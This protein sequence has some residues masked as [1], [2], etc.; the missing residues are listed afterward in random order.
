MR[1]GGNY[2][3]GGQVEFSVW[4]PFAKNISVKFH[5]NR[6]KII[7]L[8][9][10]KNGYW[11]AVVDNLSPGTQ[12]FYRINDSVDRPDPA[13]HSQPDGIH[14]SSQIVDH[15][16]FKWEDEHYG[17]HALNELIIYEIHTGTFT[18]E[19]TFDAIIA[20]LPKLT[21]LGI[22]SI[23][24]MP[25]SQF[26][27]ERNWGYDGVHPFAVQNT[28]GGPCGLKRLV[29][30]CH[31]NNFAVILDVVYNH[32]GPEGNY[33]GEFGPYFTSK[34]KTPWGDAINFDDEYSND[35][36]NFFIESALH[37][38]SN[39]HINALRID[40]V[41]GI[42]DMSAKP[43]LME[44]SETIEKFS[45]EK[46][47]NHYLI[48]ESDLNDVKIIKPRVL[49]GYG[50]D[51][52]WCDDF[53]HCVHTL[54]TGEASGYYRDFGKIEQLAKSISEGFVYSGQYSHFRKRYFG[55][56]TE[57]MHAQSFIV[58]S[59]NHDQTGNRMMGE[60]LASLT[61][62]ESLKLTAGI[63]ILSPFI[64]LIFMGEEYGETAP[65]LYFISHIDENLRQTVM[66][67]RLDEFKWNLAAQPADPGDEATFN[68]S[69]IDWDKRK[70]SILLSFYKKLI[71]IRREITA[72]CCNENNGLKTWG[73]EKDKT[74]IM[75]RY[76]GE[77]SVL[78]LF[79][80]SESDAC[81]R[82]QDGRW[83]KLLDS[84]DILWSGPGAL[85]PENTEAGKDITL[86]EKSFACYKEIKDE[87]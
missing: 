36:R 24:L 11:G 20:R 32:L 65:F 29:N 76:N 12:Y 33:L 73:F 42:I 47:R 55:N 53:H 10:Q 3:G 37:W 56:S 63:T 82:I 84:S 68:N 85:A 48:A 19:G 34:Y 44:L 23:E 35:V 26:P 1:I 30:A 57:N 80:F 79:N 6:N 58:F 75:K 22:N 2:L 27:G 81:L 21:E 54:I 45:T 28:Y 71:W 60:R 52:Q 77:T 38:F 67:G 14:N 72:L 13:S 18:P 78:C 86:K 9:L 61:S 31:K 41:H 50:L 15:K 49:G 83:H 5:H 64:P 46:K 51:A 17:G 70:G 16:A 66:K 39:Y 8:R 25:L 69:K 7:P 87:Q 40:A 59:Q 43:F 4:A 74:L 62:F